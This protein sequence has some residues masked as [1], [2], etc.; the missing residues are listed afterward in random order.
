MN[1]G[2]GLNL[3]SLVILKCQNYDIQILFL[4]DPPLATEVML[5]L[6][7]CHYRKLLPVYLLDVLCIALCASLTLLINDKEHCSP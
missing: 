2:H 6:G 3:V 7:L 4:Y 1:G 5:D